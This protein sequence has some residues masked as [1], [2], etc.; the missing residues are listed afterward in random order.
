[1]GKGGTVPASGGGRRA[2]SLELTSSRRTEHRVAPI[3]F[4][5]PPHR[6]PPRSPLLPPRP[7][8]VA[9]WRPWMA[10]PQASRI[11]LEEGESPPRPRLLKL[12]RWPRCTPRQHPS[13]SLLAAAFRTPWVDPQRLHTP[14]GEGGAAAVPDTSNVLRRAPA[15]D[16]TE[17]Q[18]L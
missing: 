3:H 6:R 5:R 1:M 2:S 11:H 13:S 12:G 14:Q 17:N 7:H 8:P 9:L 10:G 18:Q 15:L 16:S 4:A